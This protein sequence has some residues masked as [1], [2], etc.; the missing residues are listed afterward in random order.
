MESIPASFRAARY[1]GPND[2]RVEE[3]VMPPL[4]ERGMIVK[5]LACGLSR[6]DGLLLQHGNRKVASQRVLGQRIAGEVVATGT[7]LLRFE[8]GDLVAVG[9][10][11][12]G[13]QDFVAKIAPDGLPDA[14]MTIG[15]DLDGGL[16]EYMVLSGFVAQH[17]PVVKLPKNLDPKLG[18]LVEPISRCLHALRAAGMMRG[19]RL[20]VMGAGLGGLMTAKTAVE[21]FDA[22]DVI[23]TEVCVD[24]LETA[25]HLGFDNVLDA[26]RSVIEDV[27][28]RT[29]QHGADIVVV[30]ATPPNVTESALDLVAR[31]GVVAVYARPPDSVR[32]ISIPGN[33]LYDQQISVMGV[34]GASQDEFK[35]A[36]DILKV[37]AQHWEKLISKSFDLDHV[38]NAFDEVM[39]SGCLQVVISPRV[40]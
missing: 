17:G 24:R 29:D 36:A 28:R 12:P 22:R 25:R 15:I 27:W 34:Q 35:L 21:H 1:Y 2:L 20:V 31:G 23:I 11:I 6:N 4:D 40:C 9:Q 38:E 33:H 30:T 26:N 19:K 39:R 7:D 13:R 3:V 14:S 18:T 5:V 37:T 10:T 8:V 32:P 16:A